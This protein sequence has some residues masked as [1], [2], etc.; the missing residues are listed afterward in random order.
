MQEHFLH[1]QGKLCHPVL[2]NATAPVDT[3]QLCRGA[4]VAAQLRGAGTEAGCPTLSL[5]PA[6][7]AHPP[8]R[9]P[10]M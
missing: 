1:H 10:H 8:K 6:K 9:C 2:V 4:A 7:Q 3:A 5:R